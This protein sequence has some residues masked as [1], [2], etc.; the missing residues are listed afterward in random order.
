MRAYS[1]RKKKR[2]AFLKKKIASRLEIAGFEI[3]HKKFFATIQWLA[4]LS[5][6]LIYILTVGFYLGEAP[7]LYY[8]WVFL[9]CAILIYPFLLLTFTLG[10]FVYI[11][12]LITRRREVIEKH[13]PEFLHVVAANIRAGMTVD[14][15]LWRSARSQFGILSKEIEQVAKKSMIGHDLTQALTDLGKKYDSKI[16]KRSMSLI[17]EGMNA[18]SEIGDLLEN[19][20]LNLEDIELRKQ[21]MVANVTAYIIFIGFAVIIAAPTLFAIAGQ[22]LTIIQSFGDQISTSAGSSSVGISIAISSSAISQSD[23]FIFSVI[24]LALTSV[25]SCVIISAIKNGNAYGALK[26]SPIF[27]AVSLGL[28]LLLRWVLEGVFYTIL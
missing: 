23:F 16:L 15:A 12:L 8:L 25:V 18:G 14:Q 10:S 17:I 24:M 3:S 4:I 7:V 9:L 2:E 13:F 19:I 26:N 22:L 6:A 27:F 20:A 21:S 1:I 11:D 28:F 5:S